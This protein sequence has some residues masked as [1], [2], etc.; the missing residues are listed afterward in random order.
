MKNKAFRIGAVLGGLLGIL[1]ALGMDKLS[2]DIPGGGWTAAVAHD[3]NLPQTGPVT[4]ALAVLAV[5]I[6]V[7]ISAGLGG[8]CGLALERFFRIFTQE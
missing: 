4:F 8:L 5:M 3:L 1:V 2:G 6:M 7:L